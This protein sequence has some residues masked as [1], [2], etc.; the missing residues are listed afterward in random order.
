MNIKEYY[1]TIV[2]LTAQHLEKNCYKRSGKSPLFY[3][4]NEDKSKGYLIGFRKSV[5]NTPDECSFYIKFG[6]VSIE[7]LFNFGIN[8]NSV[9]LQDMKMMLMNGISFTDYGHSLDEFIIKNQTADD[10]FKFN[11]LPQ[12]E[13]ILEKSI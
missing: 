6:S 1:D 10:Y 13:K 11:I 8:C 3:R 9:R 5:Y 4:Y 2:D 12:L 7:D